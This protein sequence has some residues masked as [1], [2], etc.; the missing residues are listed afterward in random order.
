MTVYRFVIGVVALVALL[1]VV[2]I[3]RSLFAPSAPVPAPAVAGP[4]V[5]PPTSPQIPAPQRQQRPQQPSS[6]AE[7][8]EAF[9]A[10]DKIGKSGQSGRV[11]AEGAVNEAANNAESQYQAKKA[12]QRKRH[13]EEVQSLMQ[14]AQIAM[15]KM[16]FDC[17]KEAI[18]VAKDEII[19]EQREVERLIYHKGLEQNNLNTGYHETPDVRA[20]RR[21]LI[22]D[23]DDEIAAARERLSDKQR[24]LHEAVSKAKGLEKALREK[25]TTVHRYKEE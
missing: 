19:A 15:A 25:T 18:R 5:P 11:I 21:K 13:F 6:F 2:G 17:A 3:L 10:L 14:P 24:Q 16:E 1:I 23:K 4:S 22:K 20:F 12:R 7:T 9:D 8:H